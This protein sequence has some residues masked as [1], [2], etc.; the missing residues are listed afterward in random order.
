M[1]RSP[2]A[3]RP[4]RPAPRASDRVTD[5]E[6][7][8][9][10]ATVQ[11]A[12]GAGLVDL[13]EA[14]QR[15]AVVWSARTAGELDAALADLPATWLAQ[16]RR[17]ELAAAARRAARATLPAHVL[18][19]LGLVALLVTIW[20]LTTP[21]GYFWPVWPA[22]GTAPSLACHVAAARRAAP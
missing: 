21:G 5:A 20:A 3:A 9:T 4:D 12:V 13:A 10:A 15:L 14:D 17:A 2:V 18:G 16:Q 11:A 7:S 19:W 1:H 22:L 8:R 6:R